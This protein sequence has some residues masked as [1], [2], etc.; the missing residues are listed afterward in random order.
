MGLL[1]TTVVGS[2][3]SYRGKRIGIVISSDQLAAFVYRTDGI[4]GCFHTKL[5][6]MRKGECWSWIVAVV[7]NTMLT[8]SF[9]PIYNSQWTVAVVTKTLVLMPVFQYRW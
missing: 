7:A 5:R 8:Y 6:T 1:H 3:T 9:I 2:L 4:R